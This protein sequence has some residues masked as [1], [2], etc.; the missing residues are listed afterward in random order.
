MAYSYNSDP[1]YD[2]FEEAKNFLRVLFNPSRAVQAR[3]LT[4]LQTMLQNQVAKFANHIFKNNTPIL[5][6]NIK[7]NFQRAFLKVDAL[8]PDTGLDIDLNNFLGK[9]ITGDTS[10]ASAEIVHVD[11]INKI[12][13][14][15]YKGGSFDDVTPDIIA[16]NDPT[17]FRAT[18]TA[19]SVG[20]ATFANCEPGIIYSNGHFVIVNEQTHVVEA[21]GNTGSHHIGYTIVEDVVTSSDD[22]TLFD[23]AQGSFNFNAPGADRYRVTLELSSY[24]D[25]DIGNADDNFFAL[26]VTK[27]GKIILDQDKPQ[28]ADILETMARRTYD[29][30]G[31]YTVRD[32]PIRIQTNGSDATKLD[33]T[34][35]PGKAYVLGYEYEKIASTTIQTD[36]GRDFQHANQ[37]TRYVEY[38]P[39]V[40][41]AQNGILDDISGL[42][43]VSHHEQ[44]TLYTGAG[45]T[46]TQILDKNSNPIT[47]RIACV[48]R[49]SVG[50]MRVF[51][52]DTEGKTDYLVSAR[53][54]VG[55][56]S[57]SWANIETY[58]D[59][60]PVIG[61]KNKNTPIIS[62][63]DSSVAVKEITLNQSTFEVLRS[64]T[65]LTVS[66]TPDV[67]LT[68]DD[69]DS[70]W[71]PASAGGL[72]AVVKQDGTPID[73]S[74]LTYTTPAPNSGSNDTA[75]ISGSGLTGLVGQT[76]DVVVKIGRNN[77]SGNP[78]SKAVTVGQT[79]TA[80]DAN[81]KITLTHEDIIG[82][83]SVIEDPAGA[84]TPVNLDIVTLD[85]GQ[86]D[87]Y[88][89]PG[90]V[91]NLKSGVT[92]QVNYNYYSHG[93]SP[94]GSYF[95]ANSYPDYEVI[96]K[97]KTENGLTE[98]NLRNC[99]DFRRKLS[100]YV[101]AGTDIIVSGTTPMTLEY[102]YYVSRIDNVYI[103]SK[104]NFGVKKGIPSRYPVK[105]NGVDDA[106]TLFVLNIT[107]YTFKD[108][109]VGITPVDNR[110]Y[111]MRDIGE[112]ET[113]I[114]GLEYYTSLN[115]LEKA[116][117]ELSITDANGLTK[118]KH[119]IFV[120]DFSSWAGSQE[121][122]ADFRATLDM[123]KNLVR[124]PF[125]IDNAPLHRVYDANYPVNKNIKIH[126]NSVTLDYTVVDFITQGK[127]S[128]SINVNPYA[129]F[130]WLGE[131]DLKPATDYWVDIVT[132]PTLQKT[133][134]EPVERQT[135][136]EWN[137]WQT[138]WSGVQATTVPWGSADHGYS[139][140]TWNNVS[141]QTRSGVRTDVI[142]TVRTER[143]DKI[144]SRE[145]IPFM[146]A[147]RIWYSAVNMRPGI[148]LAAKFDGVNVSGYCTNLT[149]DSIGSC[150]GYFDL[151]GGTF[152]VGA[153]EFLLYDNELGEDISR[154]TATYTAEGITETHQATITTIY[155]SKVTRTPVSESQ[156]VTTPWV[157]TTWSDPLAQ[158]FLV[159]TPSKNGVFLSSITL[160]F[161]TK[162][163]SLP[164]SV[165]L[166]E[167]ENG[168]PTQRI[169]PFS[170]VTVNPVDVNVSTNGSAATVFDFS[171]PVY[172]Q[173]GTEYAFVVMTN[174]TNYK[175]F[176][177]EMG[178]VDLI[179]GKGIA[180]QP[181]A[182]V[183]FTS[184]N[185]ST[186]TADQNSDIKFK[187][188]QCVFDTAAPGIYDL[189]TKASFID[190]TSPSNSF[191]LGETVVGDTSGA[192]GVV[193]NDSGTALTF[194][195]RNAIAFQNGE[196]LTG[197]SS[198]SVATANSVEYTTPLEVNAK[199]T[200]V[201]F[202]IDA[203]ALN[204]TTITAEYKFTGDAAYTSFENS[205]NINTNVRKTVDSDTSPLDVKMTIAST[206]SNISPVISLERSSV[207]MVNNSDR[208]LIP[209]D[210][211]AGGVF[212]I[213][214]TI[215]GGTSGATGVLVADDGTVLTLA[216]HNDI[217][218]QN[219]EQITGNVS[220]GVTA[221]VNM[222]G[223]AAEDR[224]LGTY[225]TIPV[226]IIN[227]ADD[228]RVIFDAY[229][230]QNA[231]FNVFYSST[232]Y[233]PKYVTESQAGAAE[234][235]VPTSAY[236]G[237]EQIVVGQEVFVYYLTAGTG[238]FQNFVSP[239]GGTEPAQAVV[240]KIDDTG[241]VYL[242]AISNVTIFPNG[243]NSV[244]LTTEYVGALPA[245]DHIDSVW[246]SGTA[247]TVGDLVKHKDLLWKSNVTSATTAEPTKNGTDWS[248]VPGVFTNDVLVEEDAIVWRP[249]KLEKT[250]TI[251]L[252]GVGEYT[253]VPDENAN[254][255]FNTFAIKV[256]MRGLSVVDIPKIT[257]FRAIAVI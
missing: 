248:Q 110:R 187:I 117:D 163:A 185:A 140:L 231:F 190:Y 230:P 116:A 65:G 199:A 223:S 18:V 90:V 33:L 241:K 219:N 48:T 6:A 156:T 257:N 197:Q 15:E 74:T 196:G 101:G 137:S 104:G 247:R 138:T 87:Y 209:Y 226:E 105:P 153:K 59:G 57:G 208:K 159:S 142:P 107:P 204:D 170:K 19:G 220:S 60:L 61:N 78:R 150:V 31:N 17:P 129:V 149:T 195:T 242:K 147:R 36:K 95:A 139:R 58:A 207:T 67:V 11:T 158:S 28:Y 201:N 244:L 34:L 106:M 157:R 68:A 203:L 47:M 132:L 127:A 235:L 83:T 135:F 246:E 84:A 99:I 239:T 98:Y 228:L 152:T 44:V 49:N 2:D 141:N 198:A 240:T 40:D 8:D 252:Q 144:V 191:E 72:V 179:D 188:K 64:Y 29:E 173:E 221:N 108:V 215:T 143:S 63:D 145:V 213:G 232:A 100:D 222:P 20:L 122:H 131:V 205:T 7:V 39:Y 22:S 75:T 175:V 216:W 53:S 174:S 224:D 164:V 42:L 168:Y 32:F 133:I 254:E 251:D 96:Y 93:V 130:S 69:T 186:W 109:N 123:K 37:V 51:L 86:R 161:E 233:V 125:T 192:T 25:A 13:Y 54:I 255:E 62:V 82:L 229:T 27:N 225:V 76:I 189:T 202:G 4:Q 126:K 250:P 136:T 41:I 10:N 79:Q 50:E 236:A 112:L 16:T 12:V 56:S 52:A 21:E 182:G 66:A 80:A 217:A 89:G 91:S 128:S 193:I 3:E 238:E 119:G 81:G 148:G 169:L 237:L 120:D 35:E 111:T 23:P 94:L 115:A 85:N 180:E 166:V 102:D 178:A 43:D 73:L 154:A 200:T 71:T 134:G 1:Y 253:Y 167:M 5:G 172:L 26:V 88:Y 97:Y 121:Q 160:Y 212:I 146:R 211:L 184:Q 165:H 249:M 24:A 77:G 210:T 151:P 214:E 218:F 9:T 38:G 256:E 245:A 227:P 113:R 70:T 176:R 243:A 30:S 171:D 194:S 181:Y 103:D 183:M 45:G 55:S 234:W 14:F 124:C 155:G 206:D 114:A 162:D 92:Y 118:F 46:G 177:A